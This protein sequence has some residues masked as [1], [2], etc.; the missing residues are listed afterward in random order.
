[1]EP[2]VA[3]SSDL[4]C[5]SL[6][7]GSQLITF[8]CRTSELEYL[9]S[10][11]SPLSPFLHSIGS[12]LHRSLWIAN[13]H[14]APAVLN[15]TFYKVSLGS[16]REHHFATYFFF[17]DVSLFALPLAL[18]AISNPSCVLWIPFSLS[19]LPHVALFQCL[20]TKIGEAL[21]LL[22]TTSPSS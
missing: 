11:W 2:A 16:G 4:S 1:M 15:C 7:D 18:G 21:S 3:L 19:F 12:F 8:F 20:D 17:V 14:C 13:S 9:I 6:H 5:F 10:H 22:L